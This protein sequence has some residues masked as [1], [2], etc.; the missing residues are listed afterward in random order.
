M[1]NV[2]LSPFLGENFRG[3][4]GQVVCLAIKCVEAGIQIQAV[5]PVEELHYP[6]CFPG[7]EHLE[8]KKKLETI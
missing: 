6:K 7:E 3:F 1:M 2:F 4:R 5:W 8:V